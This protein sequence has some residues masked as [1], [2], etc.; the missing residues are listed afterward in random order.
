MSAADVKPPTERRSRT[1]W[2]QGGGVGAVIGLA[3]ALCVAVGLSPQMSVPAGGWWV[4]AVAVAT[5]ALVGWLLG[6]TVG[7]F[8]AVDETWYES[9]PGIR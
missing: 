1:V 3:F 2:A 6:A 8:V 9:Q 4:G 7:L 5:A